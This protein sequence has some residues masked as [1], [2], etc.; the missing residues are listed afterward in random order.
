MIS[1]HDCIR[2]DLEAGASTLCWCWRVTRRDGAAFG[3][4]DHDGPL[5]VD[6][7]EH[8]PMSGFSPGERTASLGGDAGEASVFG[9]LDDAR[10]TAADLDAGVWDGAEVR[11]KRVDWRHPDRNAQVARGEIISVSR[12][13]DAFEA[14]IAGLSARLERRIGRSLGR[15]CDAALGDARCGKD[16]TSA[17]FRRDAVVTAVTQDGVE[18]DAPGASEASGW[19]EGGRITWSSVSAVIRGDMKSGAA[20]LLTLGRSDVA[21]SLG[22]AVTLIAG[23]DKQPGTCAA[24]F[25]NL[26]NFR[27]FPHMPGNDLLQRRA[28]AE[29]VRDGGS[30]TAR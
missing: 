15:A 22:E 6:G 13:G 21:P 4:T 19:F 14:D 24:K 10:I 17:P 26:L 7:L 3:F 1:L 11:L 18:V 2:A 29:P 8:E 9:A 23:C 28:A 20:R 25:N 5:V 27:G 30:R 16:I 12:R